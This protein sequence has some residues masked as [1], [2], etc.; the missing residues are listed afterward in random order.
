MPSYWHIN[1]INFLLTQ[2]LTSNTTKQYY[3]FWLE[4]SKSRHN[5]YSMTGTAVFCFLV[6][7]PLHDKLKFGL[8]SSILTKAKRNTL[9]DGRR[10]T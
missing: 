10:E 5:I 9:K 3:F 1:I 7:H 2:P 8:L 6:K 4:L